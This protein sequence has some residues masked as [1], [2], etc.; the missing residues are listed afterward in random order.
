MGL[1]IEWMQPFILWSVSHS[2]GLSQVVLKWGQSGSQLR[3]ENALHGQ[4]EEGLRELNCLDMSFSIL[5]V[6]T[7][8]Q[9]ALFTSTNAV[10]GE[11]SFG[12]GKRFSRTAVPKKFVA[13]QGQLNPPLA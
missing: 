4:F 11:G 9:D 5:F 1:S 3:P 2:F 13:L 10:R 8:S 7:Q 12:K 6:Q